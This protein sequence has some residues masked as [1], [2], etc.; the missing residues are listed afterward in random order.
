ME[1]APLQSTGNAAA[2]AVSYLARRGEGEKSRTIPR[3]EGY[4]AEASFS[5]MALFSSGSYPDP[6]EQQPCV[7]DGSLRVLSLAFWS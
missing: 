1:P 3:Q 7:S 2:I 4:P 6:F 5:G